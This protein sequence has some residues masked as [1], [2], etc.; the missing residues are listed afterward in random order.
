MDEKYERGTIE[1]QIHPKKNGD[2]RNDRTKK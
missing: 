1:F 2:K